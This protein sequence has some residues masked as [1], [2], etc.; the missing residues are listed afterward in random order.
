M[1]AAAAARPW[2]H[3][4]KSALDDAARFAAH[5]A[6]MRRHRQQRK[7]KRRSKTMRQ[8]TALCSQTSQSKSKIR[9]PAAREKIVCRFVVLS[10]TASLVFTST[11]AAQLWCLPAQGTSTS[12]MATKRDA[13]RDKRAAKCHAFSPLVCATVFFFGVAAGCARHSFCARSCFVLWA[14]YFALRFCCCFLVCIF[15]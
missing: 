15:F 13:C 2:W 3:R 11:G 6:Q 14:F 12:N 4:H 8:R 7:K 5:G 1:L 10:R 9:S